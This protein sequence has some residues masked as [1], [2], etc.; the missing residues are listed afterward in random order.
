[1]MFKVNMMTLLCLLHVL[2]VFSQSQPKEDDLGDESCK[3]LDNTAFNDLDHQGKIFFSRW[4]S[5]LG[6]FRF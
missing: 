2:P 3:F 6:R 5:Y 4:G 1:M